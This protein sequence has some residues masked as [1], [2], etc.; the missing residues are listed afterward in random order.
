MKVIEIDN[1]WLLEVA[2]HYFKAKD[3]PGAETPLKSG[4]LQCIRQ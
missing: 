3:I 2:P 4:G 1:K